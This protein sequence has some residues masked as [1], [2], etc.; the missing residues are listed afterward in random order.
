LFHAPEVKVSQKGGTIFL[1]PYVTS[2]WKD[3]E[4]GPFLWKSVTG[5]FEWSARVQVTKSQDTTAAPDAGFQLGGLMIRDASGDAEN[6]ILLGIGCMGNPQLKLVS[7][8]T[9]N[10]KTTTRVT[11]VNGSTFMLRLRR[12]GRTVELYHGEN[13]N[14]T[15]FGRIVDSKLSSD[16]QV[17]IAGYT[18]VPGNGP[19]RHPDLLIKTDDLRLVPIK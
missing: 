16:I 9:M 1:K 15:E 2:R 4:K 5:D 8:H 10:G 17:G 14:W 3:E 7:Q 6:H 11:K 19:K 12:T 13:G 18:Y